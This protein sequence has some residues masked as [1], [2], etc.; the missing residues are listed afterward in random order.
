VPVS[1]RV[2]DQIGSHDGLALKRRFW[3]RLGSG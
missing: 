3:L 2:D 1:R